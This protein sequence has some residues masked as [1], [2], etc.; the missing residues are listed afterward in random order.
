MSYFV[1]ANNGIIY[2]INSR[3]ISRK[4]RFTIQKLFGLQPFWQVAL[5]NRAFIVWIVLVSLAVT[6]LLD[7][8]I[9]KP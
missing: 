6:K 4:V 1:A 2:W 7:A 8:S 9:Y 5:F 3:K